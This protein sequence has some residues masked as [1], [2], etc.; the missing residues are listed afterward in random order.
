MT[1][2]KFASK[3]SFFVGRNK[4][5]NIPGVDGAFFVRPPTYR[6][7]KE[8]AKAY[9]DDPDAD[10]P[11]A[12]LIVQSLLDEHGDPIFSDP[13]ELDDVDSF[14]VAHIARVYTETIQEGQHQAEELAKNSRQV[15]KKT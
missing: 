6:Q 2:K 9:K 5:I 12:Q 14:I 10:A 1:K 7:Q 13:A 4:E 11:L 15:A 8:L 3:T